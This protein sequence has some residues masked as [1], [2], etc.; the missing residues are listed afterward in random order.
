MRSVRPRNACPGRRTRRRRGA[1]RAAG[2]SRQP[3]RGRALRS[4][5]SSVS[6]RRLPRRV[7]TAGVVVVTAPTP[8]R[9]GARLA[10]RPHR[11]DH[12]WTS[13]ATW[14]DGV[15]ARLCRAL[16]GTSADLV[17]IFRATCG[18]EIAFPVGPRRRP[19]C[20]KSAFARRRDRGGPRLP[21]RRRRGAGRRRPRRAAERKRFRRRR[22]D[23]R[24]RR[25]TAT[26]RRARAPR[27]R[28]P[29]VRSAGTRG[30][31]NSVPTAS[32]VA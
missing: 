4:K 19:S 23:Q 12:R 2:L 30:A 32:S 8:V 22:C 31:A 17:A 11:P 27:V 7:R 3:P 16:R 21:R 25:G 5:S 15:A 18:T 9:R 1:S 13:S 29:R 20:G 28:H 14:A 24:A 10:T 6:I 26:P